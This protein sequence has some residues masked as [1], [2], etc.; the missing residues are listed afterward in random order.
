[1]I[2]Q[3]LEFFFASFPRWLGGL[4]YIVVIVGAFGMGLAMVIEIL[5]GDKK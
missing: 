2:M 5:R 4:I 1:M 3:L